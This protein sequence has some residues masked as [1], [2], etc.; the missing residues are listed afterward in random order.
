M[1]ATIKEV[2]PSQLSDCV[3]V[4]RESFE[5]VAKRFYLTELNC[6]THTSFITV[7]R[8]IFEAQNGVLMYALYDNDELSGFVAL[9][10]REGFAA[11]RHLCVLPC[12]Q[13]QGYGSRL[14]ELVS[15][16]ALELGY[17]KLSAAI[18]DADKL[19]K[20]FYQKAGYRETEKREFP[21]LPFTVCYMEKEL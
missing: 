16:K 8:L 14:L 3:R 19:L 20:G 4:I 6:P 11:V 10:K 12:K 21:Q 1:I 15:D 13:R 7:E 9:D 5:P 2:L 18:I 17:K